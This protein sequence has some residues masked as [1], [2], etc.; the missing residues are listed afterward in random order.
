M[1]ILLLIKNII[2]KI[3]E[4]LVKLSLWIPAPSPV[5][6]LEAP[7]LRSERC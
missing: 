1:V 4:I 5:F 2:N 7:V 3:I 6:V